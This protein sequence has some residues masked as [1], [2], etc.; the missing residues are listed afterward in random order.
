MLNRVEKQKYLSL[1]QK[2]VEQRKSE[3][4]DQKPVNIRERNIRVAGIIHDYLSKK[5]EAE[6]IV[7]GGLEEEFEAA[8]SP[9]ILTVLVEYAV[10]YGEPFSSI[11]EAL[12]KEVVE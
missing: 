2:M 10:K 11:A 7:T 5:Y 4:L 6:V 12:K 1:I 8:N 9:D 3:A